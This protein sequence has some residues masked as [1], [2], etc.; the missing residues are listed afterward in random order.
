MV[1]SAWVPACAG[2][3]IQAA[4]RAR[5]DP[6]FEANPLVIG[7][8]HIRFYGAFPLLGPEGLPLGAL[9]VLDREPRRLRDKE[10]KALGELA[11][12]ASD[13]IKRRA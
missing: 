5:R 9:C 11:A 4:G 10:I 1:G 2:T 7:E 12:I 8:P 3:T 6:R 13:E